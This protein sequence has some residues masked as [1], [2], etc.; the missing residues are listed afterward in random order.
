M[1]PV[2]EYTVDQLRAMMTPGQRQ[3]ADRYVS[4][5]PKGATISKPDFCSAVD[6]L[7][8]DTVQ[9]MIDSHELDAADWGSGSKSYW[10]ILRESAVL[11][12]HKR[13]LGIRSATTRT[14]LTQDRLPLFDEPQHKKETP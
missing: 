3:L 2:A 14:M 13:V 10:Y 9:A 12:I 1:K 8:P 4:R 7:H 5:L 11:Q 6:N